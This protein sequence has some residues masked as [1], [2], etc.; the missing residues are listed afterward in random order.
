VNRNFDHNITAWLGSINNGRD[1][2][3][4]HALNH[5]PTVPT[6]HNDGEFSALQ[7]LLVSKPVV[8]RQQDVEA[9]FFRRSKQ[10]SIRKGF[11]SLLPCSPDGVVRKKRRD[12]NGRALIEENAHLFSECRRVE[13][14]GGKVENG[15]NLF[16]RQAII[17]RYQLVNRNSVF[18]IFEHGGNRHPGILE[19][20]CAAHPAWYAFHGRTLRP[21][22]AGHNADARF[23]E[24]L[25]PAFKAE[26]LRRRF[27]L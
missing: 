18:Q 24:F 12:L 3:P 2:F 11:P 21:I 20:P 4:D 7:I 15:L 5:S 8:R 26:P 25:K 17:E 22:K 27:R 16:P 14:A 19:H 10:V 1:Y 23:S 13:A 9:G 6:E